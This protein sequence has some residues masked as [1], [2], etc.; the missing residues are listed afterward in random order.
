M[1]NSYNPNFYES[2]RMIEYVGRLITTAVAGED[3]KVM[4]LVE[5]TKAGTVQ[6]AKLESSSIIYGIVITASD[7]TGKLEYKKGETVPVCI[8]MHGLLCEIEDNVEVGMEIGYNIN[9]HKL[10]IKT[11]DFKLPYIIG[12][13]RRK[14]GETYAIL[15]KPSFNAQYT[16]TN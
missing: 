11:M 2:R 14:G 3:L 6:K 13:I 8:D 10:S 1:N 15:A 5:L 7:H 16:K 4:Q 9:T 12:E